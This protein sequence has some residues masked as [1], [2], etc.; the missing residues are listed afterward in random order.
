MSGEILKCGQCGNK[1]FFQFGPYDDSKYKVSPI[2][3]PITPGL[4]MVYTCTECGNQVRQYSDGR[5]VDCHTKEERK[6]VLIA[7][8]VQWR[9]ELENSNNRT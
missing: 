6:S 8:P 4:K 3:G 9:L 2:T 1:E 5:V 7:N